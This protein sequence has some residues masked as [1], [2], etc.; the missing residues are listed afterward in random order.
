MSDG[1]CMGQTWLPHC[2]EVRM[3]SD[4][5]KGAATL[6]FGRLDKEGRLYLGWTSGATRKSNPLNKVSC[7]IQAD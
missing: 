7:R 2:E 4:R 6:P 3:R 5:V 1:Y